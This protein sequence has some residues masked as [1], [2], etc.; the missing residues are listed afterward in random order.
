MVLRSILDITIEKISL[1]SEI[2]VAN[3]IIHSCS[4][5][6]NDFFLTKTKYTYSYVGKFYVIIH[7][8]VN[9]KIKKIQ[10]TVSSVLSHSI[11]PTDR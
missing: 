9:K 7:F 10:K 2:F 5:F 8:L 1:V 6:K 4:I 3:P 11:I